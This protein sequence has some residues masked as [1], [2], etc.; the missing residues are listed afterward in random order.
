VSHATF[1][2]GRLYV[3]RAVAI[4]AAPGE[5]WPWFTTFEALATWFS[6]GHTLLKF[7][8]EINGPVE[9]SVELEDGLHHFGGRITH[10]EPCRRLT[11][12]NNWFDDLAWPTPTYLTFLLTAQ[13]QGTLVELFHHGFDVL[14]DIGATECLAYEQGW[15]TKHLIALREAVAAHS[16]TGQLSPPNGTR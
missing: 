5:V 6:R 3:R 13:T 2:P 11:L 10:Y 15:D 9:L 7:E 1:S 14:G 4:A 8:P 12:T 16:A